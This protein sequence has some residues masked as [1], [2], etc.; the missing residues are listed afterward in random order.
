MKKTLLFFALLFDGAAFA[1]HEGMQM[2]MPPQQ[3]PTDKKPKDQMP[4]MQMDMNKPGTESL[5][6][7]T[8][9]H[10]TAGTSTQPDSVSGHMLMMTRGPWRL[11][12][13]ANA[14]VVDQQQ[15]G[16]RGYDKFFSTNWF[17]PMAQR[18]VG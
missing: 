3:K 14:F 10:T 11:M 6:Q 9:Q 1:Q 13:H 12:F 18:D 15:S 2:P 4:G 5:V 7:Q 8:L 17:M 16:A